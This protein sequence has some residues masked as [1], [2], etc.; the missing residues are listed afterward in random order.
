MIRSPSTAAAV[1][2][3]DGVAGTV[4]VVAVL[5]VLLLMFAVAFCKGFVFFV[6]AFFLSCSGWRECITMQWLYRLNE[7]EWV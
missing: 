7:S 1:A 2:V 6:F 4:V 3:V 5:V